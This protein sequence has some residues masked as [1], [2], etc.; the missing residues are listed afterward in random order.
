M[1]SARVKSY[2][3]LGLHPPS[4]DILALLGELTKHN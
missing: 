1:S 4:Q 3:G 2:E